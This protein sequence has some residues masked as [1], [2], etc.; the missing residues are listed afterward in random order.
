MMLTTLHIAEVLL[1]S[2]SFLCSFLFTQMMRV[3]IVHRW[4]GT[5]R[6]DWYPWLRKVLEKSGVKVIVPE[7]PDTSTP[8]IKAWVSH[9]AKTVGKPDQQTYFVGHSIGCQT[10][11]RYLTTLP[12]NA[13]VGGVIMV[14][15]WL[16]LQN[17]ENKEMKAIAKPWLATPIDFAKVT[18]KTK[19]L[20]LILSDND[21]YVN[22]KENRTLFQKNL[23]VKIIVVR[24]KRHFTADEGVTSVLEVLREIQTVM[25]GKL[26]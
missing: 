8:T 20:V 9:L 11:L 19:N 4:D 25:G 22:L 21:P 23:P 7:M 24:G 17:L 26:K 3:F 14:A 12:Q 13:M 15:G 18:E 10:I 6:S 1:F 5:P 2:E 16:T